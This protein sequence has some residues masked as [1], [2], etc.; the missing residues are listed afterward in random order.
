MNTP[1]IPESMREEG[2]SWK[3]LRFPMGITAARV[4]GP[5]VVIVIVR[6]PLPLASRVNGFGV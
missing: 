6:I 1:N 4:E 3:I 5:V 2:K